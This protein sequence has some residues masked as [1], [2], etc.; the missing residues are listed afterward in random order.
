VN[1]AVSDLQLAPR[2]TRVATSDIAAASPVIEDLQGPFEARQRVRDA[3]G[4]VCIRAAHC[5]AIAVSTFAFGRAVDIVPAGM[6]DTLL[7]TTAIR[8]GAAIA[9]HGSVLRAG[10]G[11][12]LLA[13]G[14]DAPTFVYAPDTEVLKLGFDRRRLAQCSARL[15]GH[16]VQAPLH[17]DTAMTAGA[18]ARW[19]AL[20]RYLL[21]TLNGASTLASRELASLEEHL[22]QTLL[23]IV[24]HNFHAQPANPPSL[25]ARQF[26][27]ATAYI[28]SHA[29]DA[30]T[31]DDI[32]DAAHCSIRTLARAFAAAGEV[33]PMQY[34]HQVRLAAIRAELIDEAA[35]SKT[36]A[37]IACA[38]GFRTSANSTA[39]TAT[40]SAKHLPPRAAPGWQKTVS[41]L[42]RMRET[43]VLPTLNLFAGPDAF[44]APDHTGEHHGHQ[45]YHR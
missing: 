14:E 43:T 34:V 8:G 5:G 35:A 42:A 21:V 32:A 22:M 29:G 20:V 13:H 6:G 7:V 36:I 37:A 38:V 39:N 40:C 17:F 30:L 11:E 28:A 1:V 19:L 12:T 10:L 2:F 25:A 24:P 26:Q 15:Y 9:S 3:P 41:Y 4:S 33:A 44:S 45:T 27:L 16:E 18:G 31:L 23:G